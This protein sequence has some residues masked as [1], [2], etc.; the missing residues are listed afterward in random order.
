MPKV[1]DTLSLVILGLC[2]GGT[3]IGL[4]LTSVAKK[5]GQTGP[6]EKPDWPWLKAASTS[7]EERLKS[8]DG[9]APGASRSGPSSGSGSS[10]SGADKAAT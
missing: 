10:T 2:C 7:F 1:G 5:A 6:P 9:A 8:L 4:A 3:F